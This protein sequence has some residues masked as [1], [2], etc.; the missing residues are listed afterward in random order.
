[1][2]SWRG[3]LKHHHISIEASNTWT[4][5]YMAHDIRIAEGS[6]FPLGA[7]W[8]GEGV[9]FSIFSEHATGVELCLFTKDEDAVPTERIQIGRAH[10]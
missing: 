4:L 6:P 7:T 5:A 2:R 8:D 9:N 1:M 3:G 10:V